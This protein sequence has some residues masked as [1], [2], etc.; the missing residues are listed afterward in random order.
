MEC[1]IRHLS[2]RHLEVWAGVPRDR[3]TDP[4][5]CSQTALPPEH[6]NQSTE[7]RIINQF[8]TLLKH[9]LTTPNLKLQN[10]LSFKC[11]LLSM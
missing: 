7:N 4:P 11:P 3:T 1:N 5:I 2:L 10:S 9:R 6:R 8:E